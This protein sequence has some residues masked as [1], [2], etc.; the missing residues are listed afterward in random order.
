MA[1]KL[2]DGVKLWHMVAGSILIITF[3]LISGGV[4]N[5]S[6]MN[7]MEQTLKDYKEVNDRE[8]LDIKRQ[9]SEKLPREVFEEFKINKRP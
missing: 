4:Q 5:K 6:Q 8:H 3:Q 2:K 7:V 1:E 9:L